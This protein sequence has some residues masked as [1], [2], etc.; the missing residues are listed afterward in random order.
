M[1]VLRFWT[2]TADGPRPRVERLATTLSVVLPIVIVAASVVLAQIPGLQ[3]SGEGLLGH[4][5]AADLPPYWH[6]RLVPLLVVWIGA[7]ALSHRGSRG[8]L[9]TDRL[10]LGGFIS[11]SLYM[12]HTVWYGLWRAG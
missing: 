2:A 3:P 1:I 10:V 11:F 4:P 12:T 5:D 7:L 6:L 8:F 9:A